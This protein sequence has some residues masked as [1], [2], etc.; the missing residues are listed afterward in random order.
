MMNRRVIHIIFS[1]VLLIVVSMDVFMHVSWWMYVIIV[2]LYSAVEAYGSIVLSA[3]FFVPV[4]F[5]GNRNEGQIA[6]TFDDGP[7]PGKTDRILD[8]LKLYHVPAAFFCIGHRVKAHPLLVKRIHDEGHVLGNHSYWHGRLFDLQP[9]AA[10]SQELSD[11]D[12]AI[13]AQIGGKPK[14]FRPPYGVTNPMVAS[15]IRKGKYITVGW[16][17]RSFDTTIKDPARL[18]QRITKSIKSGDI[19]LFH[20]YS[21]SMLQVLPA[22]LDHVTKS[23]LKIVRLD[24]LLNE[25]AYV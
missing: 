4:K 1:L 15:A 17:I 19:F 2:V 10:I 24:E 25:N 12:D 18:M 20:D 5:Y 6:I 9:A 14:F 16:N 23:G 13:A 11:T 7:L 21:E 22:F 8:I 3:E